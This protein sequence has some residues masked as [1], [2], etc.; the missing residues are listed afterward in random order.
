MAVAWPWLCF[1]GLTSFSRDG[2]VGEMA[3]PSIRADSPPADTIAIRHEQSCATYASAAHLYRTFTIDLRLPDFEVPTQ[4]TTYVLYVFNMLDALLNSSSLRPPLSAGELQRAKSLW[5]VRFDPLIDRSDLAHHYHLETFR[6]GEWL[7]A[8]DPA[9]TPVSRLARQG[10]IWPKPA[11]R[12]LK[13]RHLWDRGD[14]AQCLPPGVG[15]PFDV[16]SRARAWA[17]HE[18][19]FDNPTHVAGARDT[20]GVRITFI[21]PRWLEMF[22]PPVPLQPAA[23][24]LFGVMGFAI[25]PRRSAHVLQYRCPRKLLKLPGDGVKVLAYKQHTHSLGVRGW[26]SVVHASSGR[27]LRYAACDFAYNHTWAHLE[28]PVHVGPNDE[29]V[30]VMHFNSSGRAGVTR[31]GVGALDEMLW[32]NLLYAPARGDFP[33]DELCIVRPGTGLL[34]EASPTLLEKNPTCRNHNHRRRR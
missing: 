15:M 10:Y 33:G 4:R 6:T 25:P 31:D 23:L 26:T 1:W 29:L 2:A 24:L 16:S 13:V 19:H 7:E 18:W 8:T 27:Y 28:P 3:F 20:S 5:A 32:T 30:G 34:R 9:G 14:G 12:H 21:D 11:L 17:L 22:G